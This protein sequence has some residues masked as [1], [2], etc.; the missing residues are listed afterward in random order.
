MTSVVKGPN[1]VSGAMLRSNLECRLAQTASADH[2]S[3][4]LIEG[5]LIVSPVVEPRRPRA[6]MVG[7]P[8]RHLELAANA[9]VL[10]NAGGSEEGHPI[11][12]P[13]FASSALL[14]ISGRRPP[15]ALGFLIAGRSG[16]PPTSLCCR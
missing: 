7:H 16:Q 9:K 1:V 13:S 14:A 15:A 12:V 6:L 11:L 3:S 10:G 5:D 4:Y 2:D 8:L